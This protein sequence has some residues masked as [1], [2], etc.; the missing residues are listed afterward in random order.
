VTE[1]P[2]AAP[3]EI[4]ALGEPLLEFNQR[5]EGDGATYLQGY[6]G[7]TSNMAVAA[8]RQGARVGYLTRVGDDAFGERFLALWQREGVDVGHVARDADAPTGIYFVSH[9]ER[10]HHFSYYRALS[11]ASR[12]RP[13]HV[14]LGAITDAR[15]LH[16]SGI[17]QAIAVSACDAVFVAVEA[18]RGAGT[19]V[20]YDP[21]V[22]LTLWP[23]ARA[24]AV[25]LETVAHADMC[26]PSLEDAAILF[27]ERPPE[28]YVDLLLERGAGLVALKLGREGVLV[29]TAEERHHVPGFAVESVDAT[30]AGDTFDGAFLVERLRGATLTAAARYA[31]AAAALATRGYGAVDPIPRRAEV[32][33]FLSATR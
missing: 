2:R 21:N 11:A 12:L 23:A 10:G 18:A 14:P 4:L 32:E 28:A 24:R 29:A 22:R 9:D 17:S 5:A 33:R 15:A 3:P 27:G 25:V 20:S 6:G 8:A 13:E 30:G 19:L 16:V 26:L 31:N 7:D 1:R